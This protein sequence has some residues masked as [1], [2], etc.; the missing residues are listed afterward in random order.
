MIGVCLTV[1]LPLTAGGIA[2]VMNAPEEAFARTVAY[3]R[4]CGAGSIVII[5]YN[6]IGSVFRGIGDSR[7]PLVMVAIA[8][9]CNIFGDLLLVAGFQMGAAGAAIATVLAQFVSVGISFALIRKR[10]CPFLFP[11]NRSD[12]KKR[13]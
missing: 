9:V 5:A 3:I 13:M 10:R 12:L 6:L 2:G 7:M 4:I 1:L 8:C 11:E